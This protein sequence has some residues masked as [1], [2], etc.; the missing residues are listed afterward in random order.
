[1]LLIK[2]VGLSL[3]ALLPLNIREFVFY[4]QFLWWRICCAPVVGFLSFWT[5]LAL[6]Q[7]AERFLNQCLIQIQGVIYEANPCILNSE[8]DKSIRFG[9]LDNDKNAG[10]WA[11]II[12]HEDGTFEA[13]WNDEYGARRAH[14]RLGVVKH[15]LGSHGE[16][17]VN[18]DVRLCRNIPEGDP[19]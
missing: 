6:A 7:P 9:Y 1:M 14:S 12:K 15:E 11:Y 10:H 5:S 8:S 17:W 3:K 19:L 18:E 13:F 16:C 2:C 4:P